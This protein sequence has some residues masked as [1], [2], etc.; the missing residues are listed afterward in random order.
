[1]LGFALMNDWCYSRAVNAMIQPHHFGDG[2]TYSG[3]ARMVGERSPV[4]YET[5]RTV[6]YDGDSFATMN[7]VDEPCTPR[8]TSAIDDIWDIE[9]ESLAEAKARI[10]RAV[11]D[12]LDAILE[13]TARD[14]EKAGWVFPDTADQREIHRGWL[15]RRIAYGHLPEKIADDELEDGH[16]VAIKTI[17]N[18]IGELARL[19]RLGP[20]S[21]I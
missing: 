16:P 1:M 13:Q 14:Y 9:H 18:R 2:Y 20:L 5:E 6:I 7:F 10:M 12:S 19:L 8:V 4:V 15:Y 17:K 21:D 3:W 11:A